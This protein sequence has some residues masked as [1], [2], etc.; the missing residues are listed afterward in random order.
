MF[1]KQDDS[2]NAAICSLVLTG[3]NPTKGTCIL[4]NVPMTYQLEYVVYI[5]LLYLPMANNTKT[6]SG[7]MLVMNTYPPQAATMYP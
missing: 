1:R 5:L 6:C 2:P 7:T 3:K 4:A